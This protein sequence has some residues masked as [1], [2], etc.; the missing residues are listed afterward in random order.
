MP[1][2]YFQKQSAFVRNFQEQVSSVSHYG[3]SYSSSA[4]PT[5]CNL[6][7]FIFRAWVVGLK[8]GNGIDR[9]H[10]NSAW[11]IKV[12]PSRRDTR[13]DWAW[14]TVKENCG[15]VGWRSLL[16]CSY[17]T[18]PLTFVNGCFSMTLRNHNYAIA[19]FMASAINAALKAAKY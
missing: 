11:E 6:K 9:A 17:S 8:F 16:H 7:T 14:T 5:I 15:F 2:N 12:C 1:A 3:D 18:I 10:E 19:W 13:T 4:A